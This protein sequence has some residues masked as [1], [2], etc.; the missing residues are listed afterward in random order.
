[1]NNK[2]DFNS[3]NKKMIEDNFD[4]ISENL[5]SIIN[6]SM[7]TGIFPNVWKETIVVPIE[8]VKQSIL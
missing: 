5:L 8:K 7:E 4:L 1:M 3:I 6:C 2:Y